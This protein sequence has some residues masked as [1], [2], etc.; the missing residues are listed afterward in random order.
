MSYC[1]I[2][3]AER[4]FGYTAEEIVG[5]KVNELMAEPYGSEHDEYIDRYERT[6]EAH[7]IGRIRTVTAKRKSGELFPIE[8]SVTE[9]EVD[10]DV[11]YAAFIRD[12]SEKAKLQEQ[13]VERERLATIGTTAAKIGHELANPLNGMSLTIQLL[14]QRLNRQPNPPDSQVTVDRSKTKE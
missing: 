10:E 3:A 4:T 6:G 8:L 12:I 5:R 9:I 11:H 13:L 2:A 7:A 1:L 14:E